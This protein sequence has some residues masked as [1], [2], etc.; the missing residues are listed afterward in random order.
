MTNARQDKI[1]KVLHHRQPNLAIV[2]EDVQDPRN[3]SAVMRSC[4]AVGIQQVFLITTGQA[5][6]KKFGFK[7]GR[8]ANKWVD[9]HHYTDVETCFQVLRQ[10]Y[11]TI[12]TTHLG[13]ESK[14]LYAI[15]FTQSIALVFGNEQHGVCELTRS[16][17]DGNFT[18]PQ[19]GMIPSLNISVACAVTI[20]E[21]YRQKK[22]A[23]H[24]DT[25]ALPIA[26]LNALRTQWQAED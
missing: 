24:Y 18:I 19:V 14:D 15:D 5:L 4:D 10:Q 21:A 20:Y 17:A 26:E 3:V 8:S 25:P 9:L 2:L 23:G 12:L 22:L 6:P 11:S 16:L 1:E 13:S 7:S